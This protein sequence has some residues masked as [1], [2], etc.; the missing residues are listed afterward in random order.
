MRL[1]EDI[2]GKP[3]TG[4]RAPD[5]TI[6]KDCFWAFDV[7]SELG[8]TFDSSIF[9]MR[10]R[11]YGITGFEAGY[12]VI[13][14][15]AGGVVEELP[16]TVVKKSFFSVPV[17][18]GGYFRLWPMA[19]LK[20]AYNSVRAKGRPFVIY[21]HPYEFNTREWDS[22]PAGVSA[23]YRLHQSIGRA[24]FVHKIRFLVGMGK[25]GSMPEALSFCTKRHGA[26]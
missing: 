26:P 14:A 19:F 23:F 18:G 25:F 12:S 17:G 24:G 9:P 6:T 2:T 16:V 22:M 10:T 13:K 8:I 15:P 3:V 21:C 5:F 11:R 4:F 7:M 20:A 1:I